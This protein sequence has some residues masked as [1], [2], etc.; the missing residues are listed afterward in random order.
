MELNGI[1][2]GGLAHE[3]STLDI[4]EPVKG[5]TCHIDADF[6]AYQCSAQR[7]DGTDT[8][9]FEDMKHNAEVTIETIRSLSGSEFVHLHLTP[10]T[11]TKGNRPALALIKGYQ[12][13][14]VGKE[15]PQY[16]NIMRIHLAEKYPGTLHQF[17][18]ADDGMSSSQYKAL[19]T[20]NRDLSI[21]WS[22]DKDLS[23]VPGLHL[24]PDT[25]AIKETAD[26]FG[27]I[28]IDSSKSSKKCVGLGQKF[29]W[30]QMLM[31]DSADNISGLPANW[32]G[33]QIAP[34]KI[35]PVYAHELLQ[36]VTSNAE[37]FTLVKKLYRLYGENIGFKHWRDGTPVP[38]QM[39][40]LSEAQLLW[41]RKDKTNEKCV[42]NWFKEIMI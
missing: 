39:A 4:P 36:E 33:K 22:K 20:G 23:M 3:V 11:S 38:W 29:F 10:S 2:L 12:L 5:R 13:N 30:A 7:S 9:T 26:D 28:W 1:D 15:H 19:S 34:K 6:L 40:F 25:G 32:R 14:R 42:V 37:A 8:K 18:E 21:I 41:M 31:G 24:D 16:L 27:S 17:C 35:G